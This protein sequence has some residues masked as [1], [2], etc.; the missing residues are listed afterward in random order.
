MYPSGFVDKTSGLQVRAFVDRGGTTSSGRPTTDG[1][2]K[3]MSMK[4]FG[5]DYTTPAGQFDINKIGQTVQ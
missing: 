4:W 5:A 3:A 1:T 2:L